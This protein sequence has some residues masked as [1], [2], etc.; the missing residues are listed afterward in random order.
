MAAFLMQL[1]RWGVP[2]FRS[3]TRW[4]QIIA[5][6]GYVFVAFWV[7]GGLSGKPGL[8]VFG[9]AVLL[10]GLLIANGWN[11]RSRLPL[12]NST[13]RVVAFAGWGL[14]AII[15]VSA[16]GWAAAETPTTPTNAT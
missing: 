14:V 8:T 3:G 1:K 4:K 5:T 15:F 11:L 7:I 6:L 2:G 13:S 12:L 10:V 9:L 16:W